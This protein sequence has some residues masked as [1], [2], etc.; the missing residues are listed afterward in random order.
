MSSSLLAI[1]GG[2]IKLT[3]APGWSW[4][5]FDGEIELEAGHA[6][7][8]VKG[9]PVVIQNDFPQTKTLGKS[10]TTP[11]HTTAGQ[12]QTIQ[13]LA[14]NSTLTT[15]VLS[16]SACVTEKTTG[17]FQAIV[18]PP[19]FTPDGKPDL[20]I[21]KNGTWE[22][23]ECGQAIMKIGATTPPSSSLPAQAKASEASTTDN[24][25]TSTHQIEP[26]QGK[27]TSPNSQKESVEQNNEETTTD[28]NKI[29]HIIILVAGTV[30]PINI[31]ADDK[32]RA[33]LS[34]WKE[35]TFYQDIKELAEKPHC[36]LFDQHGWSGDNTAINRKVAGTYLADRLC[37]S[38]GEKA[39][40]PGFKN[41]TVHFH[42][43]GH[44]H[45]GNLINELT[46]RIA[47]DNNW[48]ATWQIKTI[49]Y[50]STPFFQ[51]I[52]Q[53]NTTKFHNNCKIINVINQYDLTQRT[54]ANFSLF[55]LPGLKPILDENKGIFTKITTFDFS[56]E[57]KK[58]SY[59]Y[60]H[61]LYNKS[62]QFLN[63]LEQ[64][65]TN[66]KSI[67][68]KL[69]K[70]V[71]YQVAPGLEGKVSDK[72][73]IMSDDLKKRCYDELNPIQ[74]SL[75]QMI[76][77]MQKRMTQVQNQN[78]IYIEGYSKGYSIGM[79]IKDIFRPGV[80]PLSDLLRVDQVTLKGKLPNLLHDMVIEIVD[81]Y[82]NTSYLPKQE[83]LTGYEIRHIDITKK[84]DKY[85]EKKSKEFY[86]FITYLEKAETKYAD[87]QSQKDLLDIIF[88]LIAQFEPIQSFLK[89]ET[90]SLTL[91]RNYQT[92]LNNRHFGSLI[93]E[94]DKGKPKMGSLKYLMIDAHNLSCRQLYAEVKELLEKSISETT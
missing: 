22:V 24:T 51:K 53:V 41:K 78:I 11:I 4:Q 13:L 65:I 94:N 29:E 27:T 40:Y 21:F 35:G 3:P 37:G 57:K 10:Y 19:A 58:G 86:E 8:K 31:E 38:E 93:V 25:A 79:V 28:E 85:Y 1:Q 74:D 42:L 12:I 60:F 9:K 75:K 72:R 39:Y 7:I 14:D 61:S 26:N 63:E 46:Q 66:L 73:K 33:N 70:E 76:E 6:A 69:N 82:D 90:L 49:V 81:K 88:T 18:S 68:T 5:G 91:L 83:S 64:L 52:H 71:K 87:S 59:K 44:S 77:N 47:E 30:D 20:V 36:H 34:Y 62:L 48:P 16:G 23:V 84:A 67:V 2:K 32:I 55:Q 15:K 17:T 89:N 50:L 54:I 45:G 56:L 80:K 43:I 92:I